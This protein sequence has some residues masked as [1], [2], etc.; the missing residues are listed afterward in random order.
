M[1]SVDA[2]M[3]GPVSSEVDTRCGVE[4]NSRI[5]NERWNRSV[6]IELILLFTRAVRLHP[7]NAVCEWC[8][9]VR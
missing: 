2:P 3:G 8:T 4:S 5:Q 9:V 1:S 6:C 7:I